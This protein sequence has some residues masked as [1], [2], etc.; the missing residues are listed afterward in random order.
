MNDFPIGAAS[1]GTGEGG[2]ALVAEILAGLVASPKTLPAKLFYDAEGCRLFGAITE[3]P[4]YYL[5]RTETALLREAGPRLAGAAAPGSILVEYGASDESKAAFLL[6]SGRFAAY[7]PLDI[8]AGALDAIRARMA[9]SHP[10]LLVIPVPADFTA[11]VTLPAAVPAGPRFGFFPGSTIGNFEPAVA[12]R[13]LAAMRRTLSGGAGPS[14]LLVGA[15]LRKSPALLLPAYD[16]AAGVTAAFNRNVLNHV[17]RLAR[18]DFVP[19]AFAH[20]VRWNDG[21]SRIEMHL[22]SREA[23]EVRVAGRLVRFGRGETIHTENSYKHDAATLGRLGV[24]AG[25]VPAGS[26]SDAGGMF[27]IHAF[28]DTETET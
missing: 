24:Q 17:N 14:R 3:L 15:D 23:Q 5:T 16:D 19:D 20:V 21:E 25:W 9:R 28:A 6:A 8:A 11:P 10:T 4:E 26:I 22:E 12:C 27:A 2:A 1:T 7:V 13:L 18:A